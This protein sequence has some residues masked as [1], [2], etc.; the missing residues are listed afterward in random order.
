MRSPGESIPAGA[1]LLAQQGAALAESR[2]QVAE[3]LESIDDGFFAID[4]EWN[5]I[6]INQR[7]AQA[8][9]LNPEDLI[10]KNLWERWPHILGTQL[11]KYY[12]QVMEERFPISFEYQGIMTGTWYEI[13]VY[14][15]VVGISVYWIDITTRKQMEKRLAYKSL[16]LNTIH[17]AVMS[18]GVDNA[19][20]F[21]TGLPRS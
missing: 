17:E 20:S 1:A 14:P 2:Q 6:Y 16:L 9:G 3:I 4:R 10:G 21:G 11:E 13:R 7:A 15:S 5:Y 19:S 8:G 18:T 12:R